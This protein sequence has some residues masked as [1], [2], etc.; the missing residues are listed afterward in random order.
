MPKIK[1]PMTETQLAPQYVKYTFFTVDPLWRGLSESEK[2]R[3][4]EEF[5]ALIASSNLLIRAYSLMGMRSDAE[6]LLWLV[7]PDLEGINKFATLAM[8]T[9]LGQYLTVS[10]S[11]LAMTRRSTYI[12]S[13]AMKTERV[14]PESGLWVGNTFLYIHLLRHMLGISCHLR[15]AKG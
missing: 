3:S 10:H 5:S 2:K 11:Y 9:R 8:N 1:G 4:K 7:S 13:I 12:V 14:E 6:L 15:N